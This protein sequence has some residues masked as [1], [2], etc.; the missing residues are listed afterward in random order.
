MMPF[1]CL[2]RY[3]IRP[4]IVSL[5]VMGLLIIT[6]C[7]SN[8]ENRILIHG[9]IEGISETLCLLEQKTFDLVKI[10]SATPDN[11]GVFI[12]SINATET[13]IYALR[14]TPEQQVIFIAG[15]G[16]S[17]LITGNLNSYPSLI[18]ISGNEET[19]LLHSFYAYSAENLRE[20]DS[21]QTIIEKNQGTAD[22]YELTVRAD[23]L[24]NQIWER[25]KRY[26]I[27]FIREHAG[28]FST[29]LVVN[30]HFGVKPV[31][32][33]KLNQEQY[34]KVDS[35]LMARF[36]GNRHALFFHQWLKEGK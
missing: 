4:L 19:E 18:Q 22:F 25:Q 3:L 27:E 33:P 7:S 1:R 11:N 5:L 32:S 34:R 8:K 35:G 21:I 16:D 31:L 15:P 13:S 20:V 28:K 2:S 36:P 30:Y 23:S 29:L 10:D 6:S 26:E 9:R 12:L 17:I 24:F 14:V